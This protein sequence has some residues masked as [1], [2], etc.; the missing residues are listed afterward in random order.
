MK[1]SICSLL[2][3]SLAFLV[4]AV[5]YAEDTDT[6][7]LKAA[8]V[9]TD[10]VVNILDL[11]LIAAHFGETPTEDQ[12]PNPDVNRDGIVNILDLTLVSSHFGKTVPPPIVFVSTPLFLRANPEIASQLDVDDTITLTFDNTPEDI[13]V[14]AGVAIVEGKTVK[15]T[16][17]FTPGTLNLTI[18]WT[19]GTQTLNYTI[20]PSVA[21]VS[22]DPVPGSQLS[23]ND[24]ITLTFDNIPEDVKVSTGVAIVE[25]K[26]V[27]ITGP[28]TPGTLALTITWN[29]GIQTLTYT[30]RPSVAFVSAEPRVDA[31]LTVDDTITLTF[32]N[33]PDEVTVSTGIATVEGKT[34]KITGPFTPGT[35]NLTITWNDGSLT[36][37]YTVAEPDTDAPDITSGTVSDGDKDVD[38]NAINSNARIEIAFSE[39][40]SGNI[41]LQTATGADVGWLGK[42]EGNKGILELVKGKELGDETT[43]VTYVVVGKV[44]DAA[45][46][47]TDISITF[48][49]DITYDG[50]PIEVSDKTF[51]TVVLNSDV[52]IVVEFYTDW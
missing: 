4:L 12:R 18:T 19:G 24:A 25:G 26:T 42:V 35:L 36:F 32:D 6:D 37:T 38:P 15:I 11:T 8:D 7:I 50:I 44:E 20:H 49:T 9:N 16:G 33:T 29:D 23:M 1:K 3:L 28:F 40:V 31:K 30:V 14:S 46:N 22:T 21:F 41:A 2:I 43:Y 13:K 52:P 45:G 48:T 5:S 10:G 34:V 27:K 47:E 39:E 51:D 17:P